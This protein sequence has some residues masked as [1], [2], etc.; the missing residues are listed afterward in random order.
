MMQGLTSHEFNLANAWSSIAG[1]G[2]AFITARR[3]NFIDSRALSSMFI[4]YLPIRVY[5]L[6]H[7]F[8]FIRNPDWKFGFWIVASIERGFTSV[9]E[10][11]RTAE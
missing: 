1:H 4:S 3:A 5:L 9:I 7:E 8:E 2:C 10:W 11:G 6:L